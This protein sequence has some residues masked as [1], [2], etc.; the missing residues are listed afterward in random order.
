MQ[1]FQLAGA[2]V[3]ALF[4]FIGLTAGIIPIDTNVNYGGIKHV[5]PAVTQ[6]LT[7]T[8][9][10][11]IVTPQNPDP[12]ETM[13]AKELQSTIEQISGVRLGIVDDTAAIDQ[14][15][16]LVGATS[17]Y[18][19]SSLF[20]AYGARGEDGFL[21]KADGGRLIIAGGSPRGT[22]YGVY[23]F[24]E[25]QL[26]CRWY[27]PTVSFIPTLSEVKVNAALDDLQIPDFELRRVSAKGATARY[28][29]IKRNNVPIWAG[30]ANYGGG[31]A[32]VLW[33]VTLDKLVPDSLFAA[34][35]DYFA[36]RKDQNKRTVAHVCMSSEGAF[37]EALKN[38]KLAIDAD[39]R[40]AKHI[41]IGQKDNSD[42]CECYICLAAYKKYGSV[43][44][45]TVLFA[46]R[47]A[48]ELEKAGYLDMSVTFYA[49]N[50]TEHPPTDPALECR[51]NVIPVICGSHHA[52]NS[53]PYCECGQY[54]NGEFNL[55]TRFSSPE[56]WF[57]NDVKRWVE[58]A[59]RTYIYE[60]S[61]NFL[62][63]AQFFSNF[64]TMGKNAKWMLDSG[65][66]GFTYTC[67]D[68]HEA[69]FNELRNYLLSKIYWDA[70]CDVAYHMMD[71]LRSFYGE[72]AGPIKQYI[73]FVTAK[74]ASITHAF[75][76]DWHYQAGYFDSISVCKV[77]KIWKAALA[78]GGTPEQKFRVERE[79]CSWR[80]YKSNLYLGEFCLFNPMRP[81]NNEKLYD[82][83]L[84][85]GVERVTAFGVIP[86]K[87]QVDFVWARPFNWR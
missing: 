14:R 39:T 34:H 28:N 13:A 3:L 60:Y 79:E 85:H 42:Y 1:F 74:T 80:Y 64:A 70:D 21:L 49:Y 61:I 81:R 50:E 31:M 45:P 72:A 78:A 23:A 58:I 41:H 43:S 2:W 6:W 35:G 18:D 7:L 71:F 68:G 77:D 59:D 10:Y 44:G 15:E 25:E 5:E 55:I 56:P 24:L 36:W 73:N 54:R 29:A 33:D 75:D 19:A 66:T 65:V 62:N 69:A 30:D 17:L 27:T 40:G 11:V 76:F 84:A 16:I 48:E 4:Q 26:G 37:Q 82:D 12:A 87:D 63:S 32:Y 47:L 67:G 20:T 51:E 38:A 9:G 8:N 46:N 52:C 86:P 22:L 53:H 57:A 83:F